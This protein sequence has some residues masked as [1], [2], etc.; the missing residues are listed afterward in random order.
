[1]SNLYDVLGVAPDSDQATIRKA[2]KGL[3]SKFHPDKNPDDPEATAKFQTIQKAHEILSNDEKRKKYDETGEEDGGPSIEDLAVNMVGRL[4]V[5]ATVKTQ[6]AKK[7]HFKMVKD[8]IEMAQMGCGKDRTRLQDSVDKLGYLIQN[9]KSDGRMQAYLQEKLLEFRHNLAHAEEAL[10]VME[11]AIKYLSECEY[12]G[13][14][15]YFPST[16]FKHPCMVNLSG[17]P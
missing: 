9:T 14:E 16:N 17:M 4:L 3:A 6:F 13:E 10:I 5:E 15:S 8:H 7:D 12:T 11:A 1:M 2:F